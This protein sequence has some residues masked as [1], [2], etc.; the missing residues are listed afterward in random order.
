[1][2]VQ[3][4]FEGIC[5]N[6]TTQSF[7]KNV[8]PIEV[9]KYLKGKYKSKARLREVLFKPTNADIVQEFYK[10][11]FE[12]FDEVEPFTYKEAFSVKN[13]TLR[14]QVFGSIDISE[15]LKE[16]SMK[17]IKVDG[18]RVNR[19]QFSPYGEFL[20]WHEY[21]SIYETYEVDGG[22]LGIENKLYVLKCWCTST[23][24]EHY[25]W[26]NEQYA[27]DPLSA[28]ASTFFVYANII[29]YISELKRQGDVM[30]IE[31]KDG[32]A[33][34]TINQT[35]VFVWEGESHYVGERRP[36]TKEEYFGLLTAE[37]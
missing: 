28:V 23:N 5:Y 29:P 13:E 15:M 35:Q 26:I 10:G 11:M 22:K 36:L 2:A 27:N 31:F 8:T 12:L 24:K 21:D 19:K 18:K 34:D 25:L 20:G 32:F 33:M 7:E 14:A 1:M 17:R 37:S 30:L 9:A 6:M 3:Y 16:F 4:F